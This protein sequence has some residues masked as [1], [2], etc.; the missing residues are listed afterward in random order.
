MSSA[1]TQEFAFLITNSIS[2]VAA[3][4]WN[5]AFKQILKADL[6]ESWPV[7]GAFVYAVAVTLLA[8]VV[9]RT[10]GSY[11][12]KACTE[13]CTAPPTSRPPVTHV[14]RWQSPT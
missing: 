13:I 7:S 2:L 1:V 4:A 8:Y 10:I 11:A 5:D 9:S 3:F 12:K 6:L 14:P